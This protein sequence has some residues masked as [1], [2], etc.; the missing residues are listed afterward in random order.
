MEL[1]QLRYVDAIAQCGSISRAAKKL[2]M[3]QPN[4][5][6]S[7]RE[8]EEELG[9]PLFR[10]TAQGMEPTRAGEEFLVYAR[11]ILAQTDELTALFRPRSEQEIQLAVSVPRASYIGSAFGEWARRNAN[12]QFQLIYREANAAETLESVSAGDAQLGILRCRADRTEALTAQISARGLHLEP[13]WDFE[14]VALMHKSHPLAALGELTAQRLEEYPEVLHGDVTSA[15]PEDLSPT[16][17]DRPSESRILVYDRASQF[18]VLRSVRRSFMWA[19][20]LPA[21]VLERE[22]L[23]QKRCPTGWGFRD[24]AVWQGT[25]PHAAAD[26]LNCVREQ[27]RHLQENP[28]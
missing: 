16:A 12:G 10:R 2:Y 22:E 25:L 13:L 6:K 23:V 26:F 1:C 3:G 8:L 4:L 19:S 24:A 28:D 17:Q 21:S 20:P 7:L 27:I 14:R 9:R 11:E 15:S 5:S 18:E